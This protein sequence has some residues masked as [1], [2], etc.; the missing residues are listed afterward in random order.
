MP[1]NLDK[2]CVFSAAH[3]YGDGY[4]CTVYDY[5]PFG[6]RNLTAVEG[7]NRD[8]TYTQKRSTQAV[9]SDLYG[10]VPE[11]VTDTAN[12]PITYD[13]YD[14]RCG[15]VESASVPAVAPNTQ[16]TYSPFC[17]PQSVTH[18][19][20]QTST[21]SYTR[22][23]DSSDTGCPL[24]AVFYVT[25]R[26]S[27]SSAVTVN[28]F[29]AF[30]RL[31]Q[32]N[33]TD[34]AG[35]WL[36]TSLEYHPN[37][38]LSRYSNPYYAESPIYWTSYVYDDLDRVIQIT[39]PDGG[40]QRTFYDGMS[41]TTQNALDQNV[42]T[43]FNMLDQVIQ[44]IDAEGNTVTFSY[45]SH[46]DL[47]SVTGPN[48]Y[49]VTAYYDSFGNRIST[50][51]PNLGVTEFMVDVYGQE[52][53]VTR[54]DGSYKIF[55]YDDGGRPISRVTSDGVTTTWTYASPQEAQG[56]LSSVTMSQ[57]GK[58]IFT[59]SH[60]YNKD[61]NCPGSIVTALESPFMVLQTTTN[62]D[63][64]QF[65]SSTK[66]DSSSRVTSTT[67]PSGLSFNNIYN[68]FGHLEAV[69]TNDPYSKFANFVEILEKNELG[70]VTRMR[71]SGV[72]TDPLEFTFEYD[73]M[74]RLLRQTAVFTTEPTLISDLSYT[75]DVINNLKQRSDR[76]SLN[77]ESFFYDDLNRLTEAYASSP[78]SGSF[79]STLLSYDVNGNIL[80]N[81]D[82]GD[83]SYDSNRPH[84][85][86]SVAG[87][88]GVFNF[89]YDAN[90]NMVSGLGAEVAYNS[91]NQPTSMS[92]GGMRYTFEY[93]PHQVSLS[94]SV[95]LSLCPSVYL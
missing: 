41:V 38:Q 32:S 77:R 94:L 79:W 26:T 34:F 83:Y 65:V 80:S 62:M 44:T 56:K 91:D 29:D 24:G 20:G 36:I 60:C 12:V 85:V 14:P 9:V 75:W 61:G 8:G 82:V 25:I 87:T 42:T 68:Q 71:V 81:S 13:L 43:I 73:V 74:G 11:F 4:L 90:G 89:L 1:G 33:T 17:L 70:S 55:D 93:G 22:C 47:A 39:Y 76:V 3:G 95:P 7:A 5:D 23:T 64:Y 59:Q 67:L 50:Y 51:D 53:N 19:N 63:G 30:E 57:L 78:V 45:N 49:T 72:G 84:A 69:T 28:T 66:Y 16:V 92:V 31:L 46:G 86:T 52:L 21:S 2:K 10:R 88:A 27:S 58:P 37:G 6:N 35:N 15:A 18:L 48:G 40:I 54:G